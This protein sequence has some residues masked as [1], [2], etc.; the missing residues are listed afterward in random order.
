MKIHKRPFSA[1][2]SCVLCV[3]LL[4]LSMSGCTNNNAD[5]QTSGANATYTATSKGYGGDVTVTVV[6]DG[7]KITSVSAEGASETQGVGGK[8]ITEFNDG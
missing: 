7:G 5:E 8:A 3:A 4:S 6:V 1:V 2:V